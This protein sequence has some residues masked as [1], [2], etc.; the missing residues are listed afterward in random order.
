MN[1]HY[2][3]LWAL[4][5]TAFAVFAV[6]SAFEMP[7]IGDHTL[8]SSGIA[9]ALTPPKISHDTIPLLSDST[10]AP[11]D[12]IPEVTFPVP[13]D[14]AAQ[15]I[16]FIGDSM[17]EGLS[18][19]MAAYAD[20]NGHTLYCVMWYSSTSEVWGKSTKLQSYIK[21]LKPSYVFISLGANELF[22][23][24]IADKRDKYV[25]KIIEDID[26]IPY[27]W[28]GPPNWKP[29]TGINDLIDANTPEGTFFLS[30]DMDFDRSSDGAHPTR[31][32]AIE[33]LD[34]VM[35]WMPQHALHPI[36]MDL[37]DVSKSR[38][39]RLFVHQ[40]SES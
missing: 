38:P 14:T 29:D 31:A 12:T 27:V 8:K 16:L 2:F 39:K 28:I 21:R 1:K 10:L 26:S 37:P 20:K 35:R 25:K 36:K 40:P 11:K 24:N 19:R 15:T 4:L 17:L 32:S 3:M 9:Q 30:K 13:V 34:S 6:A 5:A 7:S 33:W 23:K 22:V 18:P